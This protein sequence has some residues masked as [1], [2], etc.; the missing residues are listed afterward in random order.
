VTSAFPKALETT[1]SATI[2]VRGALRRY[3]EVAVQRNLAALGESLVR[4][5]VAVAE[6]CAREAPA[7][8]Q[9]RIIKS[10]QVAMLPPVVRA[11]RQ[12]RRPHAEVQQEIMGSK[13]LLLEIIR[14]AAYDWVLYRASRRMLHKKLAEESFT[15]LFKEEPGHKDW[16]E[17]AQSGKQMTSFIGICAALDLDVDTLR[18]HIRKMTAKNVTSVGRPAEYR[19]VEI[20]E[21]RQLKDREEEALEGSVGK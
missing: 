20:R 10:P 18:G 12:A 16:D 17:R 19:R 7:P 13:S 15:W 3:G 14:R 8:I 1:T 4:L 21:T 2:A 6:L 5:D 9:A 11:V